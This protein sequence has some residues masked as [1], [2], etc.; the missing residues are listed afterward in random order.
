MKQNKL[1]KATEEE[2]KQKADGLKKTGT[3]WHNKIQIMKYYFLT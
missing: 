3:C 1:G 2:N